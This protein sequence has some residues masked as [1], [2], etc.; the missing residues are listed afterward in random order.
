MVKWLAAM[1]AKEKNIKLQYNILTEIKCKNNN[2][3][4][5]FLKGF[6]GNKTVILQIFPCV[7][8]DNWL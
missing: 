7:S 1:A 3:T 5:I 2:F 4:D 6:T 8:Y